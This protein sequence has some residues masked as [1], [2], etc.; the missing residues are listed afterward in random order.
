MATTSCPPGKGT[1]AA[2]QYAA[3]AM[4][5]ANP[6]SVSATYTNG[7]FAAMF[8]AERNAIETKLWSVAASYKPVPD[9][10][11]MASYQ[12]QDQGHTQWINENIRAWVLGA[13][14]T[15]G[16]NKFIAGY[17]QKDP[18]IEYKR[19]GYDLFAGM[20]DRVKSDT[21]D[22][23]FHVQAVRQEGHR[24]ERQPGDDLHH[25]HRRGDRD[26]DHCAAFSGPA[27]L[28]P[29]GVAVLPA[30]QVVVHG[31]WGRPVLVFP[32]EGGSAW[33]YAENGMV[34][35]VRWLVDAGRVKRWPNGS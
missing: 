35:A 16:P 24:R 33:D 14:Y 20:M 23:L 18:L 9:L 22:R 2:P 19:E 31:H 34:D 15:V 25:H 10:K 29:E 4:A 17:G 7:P 8:G 30:G 1:A 21:L 12:R 32:S 28:L 27:D 5:S 3:N 6:Y 11:L 13:N 26:H